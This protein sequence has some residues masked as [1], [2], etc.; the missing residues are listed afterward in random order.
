MRWRDSGVR[1]AEMSGAEQQFR[2]FTTLYAMAL[3][4]HYSDSQ[5]LAVVPALV[6][7]L[8]ALLFPSSVGAFALMVAAGA[9]VAVLNLP[10]ASNHLV[11]TLLIGLAFA[12]SALWAVATGNR[13]GSSG[14]TVLRWWQAA[15]GPAGLVLLVVYL[16]TVF[17]K[18]NTAFFDP[19]TSCTGALLGQLLGLNGFAGVPIAPGLVSA[20]T[21]AAGAAAA[22]REV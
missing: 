17:D 20:A 15:R 21:G 18:L 6:A 8:P 9:T 14:P 11:M 7:S 4:F 5:P 10:A 1:T 12:G 22:G 2:W 3:V 16:F 13:P 19:A